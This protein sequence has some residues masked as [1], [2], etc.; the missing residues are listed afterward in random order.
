MVFPPL[1]NNFSPIFLLLCFRRE[2]T[3]AQRDEIIESPPDSE[4]RADLLVEYIPRYRVYA[5]INRDSEDNNDAISTFSAYSARYLLSINFD[6]V[7]D[8]VLGAEYDRGVILELGR[9]LQ[10]HSTHFE[11]LATTVSD[12]QEGLISTVTGQSKQLTIL[13]EDLQLSLATQTDRVFKATT[14]MAR[15]NRKIVSFLQETKVV[16]EE[17]YNIVEAIIRQEEERAQDAADISW[18]IEEENWKELTREALDALSKNNLINAQKRKIAEDILAIAQNIQ[19]GNFDQAGKDAIDVLSKTGVIDS[20]DVERVMTDIKEGAELFRRTSEIVRDIE[21]GNLEKA[22]RDALLLLS[23]N[24]VIDA[25]DAK[26]AKAAGDII[27]IIENKNKSIEESVEKT[28]EILLKTGAIDTRDLDRIEGVLEIIRLSSEAS[29]DTDIVLAGRD[30]VDLLSKTGVIDAKD[31]K[32]MVEVI[33]K[34]RSIIQ[35]GSDITTNF[36]EERYVQAGLGVATI[37]GETGIISPQD[38]EKAKEVVN[39]AVAGATLAAGISTGNPIM[40]MS[41]ASSLVRRAFGF[42]KSKKRGPDPRVLAALARIE[43]KLNIIDQKINRVIELQ[44][45][46]LKAVKNLETVVIQGFTALEDILKDLGVE[47]G[48]ILKYLQGDE[49]LETCMR[50]IND[51]NE[52]GWEPFFTEVTYLPEGFPVTIGNFNTWEAIREYYD[53]DR[54]AW[55]TCFSSMINMFSKNSQ[56][57]LEMQMAAYTTGGHESLFTE[58]INPGYLPLTRLLDAHWPLVSMIDFDEML[59]TFNATTKFRAWYRK[60]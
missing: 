12:L 29:N 26:I 44:A 18:K 57:P 48:T 60:I 28:A 35:I 3:E 47:L 11:N 5:A 59:E 7:K 20:T 2:L 27:Q 37:L 39:L 42:G 14:D 1:K 53:T 34:G 6:E 36:K 43:T 45:E 8:I 31:A 30:A 49:G 17:D 9:Q 40:I 21:S 13:V 46:T 22:G 51:R 4:E 52:G 15:T 41:G 56:I 58:Y 24:G 23:E 50:L 32:Q 16:P 25:D 54:D 33:D 19:D 55:E 38:A 10:E